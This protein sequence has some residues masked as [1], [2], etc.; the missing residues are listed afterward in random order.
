MKTTIRLLS[1]FLGLV[2][3]TLLSSCRKEPFNIDFPAALIVNGGSHSISIINLESQKVVS[4]LKLKDARFPHHIYLNPAK[5]Q[6]AISITDT[7]LSGGHVHRGH[8]AKE[9]KVLVFAARSGDEEARLELSGMAHN[10]VF[11]PQGQTLWL[12]EAGDSSSRVL[13]FGAKNYDLLGS[14]PVG[15][16]LSEIT[17]STDGQKAYAAN[18]MDSTVTIIDVSGR[19]VLKTLEV[20]AG[21]VGAWPATNGKMYVDNETAQSIT[22]IDVVSDGV[23]ATIALG[24]KPGYVAYHG[25]R[26]ELWVSDA[27]NGQVVWYTQQSGTWTRSGQIPTGADAHAI[28]FTPD[29]KTALIT[30]QGAA[31]VSLIDVATH[32]KVTDIQVGAKPNGVALLD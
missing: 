25:G 29:Q 2:S 24:F 17:M 14:I 32:K 23:T 19:N 3:L 27:T 11:D 20:E 16:G 9:Y 7:D 18:T 1:L 28:A 22:E 26:R 10:A 21:P 5:T 6:F 31:T 15:A 8:G 30:N 4:E 13:I 12:G